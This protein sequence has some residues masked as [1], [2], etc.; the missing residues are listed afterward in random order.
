[1]EAA[2][3]GGGSNG[4]FAAAVDANDR[5]V[6]AASTATAQLTIAATIAAPTVG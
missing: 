6:A 1:M 3:N 4:V 2:V 5:M